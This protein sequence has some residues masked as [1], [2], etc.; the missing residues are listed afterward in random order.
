MATPHLYF[1]AY[2]LEFHELVNFTSEAVGYKKQSLPM[3]CLYRLKGKH[4][5][6]EGKGRKTSYFLEGIRCF[7]K[8]YFSQ[9][10]YLKR[11]KKMPSVDEKHI[12]G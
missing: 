2:F 11:K 6:K 7:L 9:K 12:N 8:H 4:S 5:K 10:S 1:S 3:D